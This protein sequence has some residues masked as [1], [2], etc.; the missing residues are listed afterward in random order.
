VTVDSLTRDLVGI[1]EQAI[2]IDQKA[3]AVSAT[4][5]L[6]QTHGLLIERRE[7]R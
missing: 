7:V 3:A 6:A 5:L 2:A 1:R 4:K